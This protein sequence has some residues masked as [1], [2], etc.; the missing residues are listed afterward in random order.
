MVYP[1]PSSPCPLLNAASHRVSSSAGCITV[2]IIER[3]KE[4]FKCEIV[5]EILGKYIKAKALIDTGNSLTCDNTDED[6]IIV[7]RGILEDVPEILNVIDYTNVDEAYKDRIRIIKYSTVETSSNVS[8]GIKVDNVAIYY[9][10]YEVRNNK[11][12]VTISNVPIKSYDAIINF[13][14]IERGNKYG[15]GMVIQNE[16]SKIS[17]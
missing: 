13:N 8:I 6:V 10:G 12:V 17:Q 3:Q 5:I 7:N 4:N 2:H 11:A 14:I 1:F 9:D 16:N 15:N